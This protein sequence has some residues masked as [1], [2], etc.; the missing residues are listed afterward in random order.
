MKLINSP[1][2][3]LNLE[4]QKKLHKRTVWKTAQQVSWIIEALVKK[5]AHPFEAQINAPLIQYRMSNNW[6]LITQK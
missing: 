2:W 1:A 3:A 6:N 4:V 5:W